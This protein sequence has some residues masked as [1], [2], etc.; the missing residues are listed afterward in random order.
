MTQ[1]RLALGTVQFGQPYGIANTHGQVAASDVL[2]ILDLARHHGIDTLDTAIGYGM[3]ESV[4]GRCGAD[5]FKVVTKLPALPP[6]VAS[7][8]D[9]V[10]SQI[11][12]SLARLR[13]GTLEAVLLHKPDQLTEPHGEAIYSALIG[14]KQSGRTRKIGISIYE[15][16]L[17]DALAHLHFDLVQA[18]LNVLDRRMVESGWTQKL[19][20]R[21]CEL[22]TRSAF[23]QGLLLMPPEARPA[24][25]SAWA[26]VWKAWDHWLE[27]ARLSPL[28]ACIRFALAV[29]HVAKVVVGVDSPTHLQAIV[30]AA[31][32]PLPEL[33][34]ELAGVP[35]YLLNPANWSR[36]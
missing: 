10:T 3:S 15:P 21:G 32:G 5:R 23:L 36:P 33:P 29:P 13:I 24:L 8:G 11:D 16:A 1:T 19:A 28:E 6:G 9:W 17:L 12:A 7:I 2:S 35:P 18:P 26:P 25:F 27:A 4:I 31:E 30:S 20:D 34:L 14:L 22:H